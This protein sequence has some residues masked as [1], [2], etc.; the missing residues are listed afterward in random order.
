MP[1]DSVALASHPASPFLNQTLTLWTE[2]RRQ[3]RLEVEHQHD[4]MAVALSELHDRWNDMRGLRRERW[5]AFE[6]DDR[7]SEDRWM[8]RL[9]RIEEWR[10][11]LMQL[12]NRFGGIEGIVSGIQWFDRAQDVG[13]RMAA[14]LGDRIVPYENTHTQL[15]EQLEQWLS[16]LTAKEIDLKDVKQKAEDRTEPL[17]VSRARK[18]PELD[19]LAENLAKDADLGLQLHRLRRTVALSLGRLYRVSHL[20]ERHARVNEGL[21]EI[22]RKQI[23]ED[24]KNSQNQYFGLREKVL[25]DALLYESCRRKLRWLKEAVNALRCI[26]DVY[27]APESAWK[28]FVNR[29]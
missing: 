1:S 17:L 26:E 13:K 24:L 11:T 20:L 18:Q 19:F 7:L 16:A 14:H 22:R 25:A 15:H 12:Q 4:H 6:N 2:R 5:D 8:E 3:I 9:G 10:G 23:T 28:K 29:F 21:F 27:R